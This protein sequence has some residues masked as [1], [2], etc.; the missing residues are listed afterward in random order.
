MLL[1][2]SAAQARNTNAAHYF[3]GKPCTNGHIAPRGVKGVC[4][5]C[6]RDFVAAYR[7]RNKDKV[8]EA[9]ALRKDYHK[10]YA[11]DWYLRNKAIVNARN[12]AWREMNAEHNQ[13][14]NAEWKVANRDKVAESRAKR[15]AA[16]T[17]AIP[18]WADFN[19]ISAIYREAAMLRKIGID[20]HVD[21]IV[22]LLNDL[23]CG[24]HVHDNLR[25]ILASENLSKNNRYVPC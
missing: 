15:R 10:A 23:V 25:V 4:V 6:Q 17:R 18:A 24:L 5:Q 13:R 11:A 3:T 12:K 14:I 21:H 7:A 16:E 20:V 1:P 9:A 22:P 8:E 2:T 19:K